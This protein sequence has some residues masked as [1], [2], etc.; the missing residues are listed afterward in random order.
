MKQFIVTVAAL[1]ATLGSASLAVAGDAAP[2]AERPPYYSQQYR[3]SVVRTLYPYGYETVSARPTD[4]EQP[5]AGYDYQAVR[6][7]PD[8][9][10]QPFQVFRN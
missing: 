5:A 9:T 10:E 6:F 3:Q 1:A 8:R 2:T 4:F 7:A